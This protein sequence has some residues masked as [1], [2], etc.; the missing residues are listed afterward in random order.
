MIASF[1]NSRLAGNA[2]TL[3]FAQGGIVG[4]NLIARH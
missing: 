2:D 3:T 1:G 4:D